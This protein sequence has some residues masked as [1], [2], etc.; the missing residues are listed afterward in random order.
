LLAVK[1]GSSVT[2]GFGTSLAGGVGTAA[3]TTA[4]TTAAGTATSAIVGQ[5]A[6]PIPLVGAAIGFIAG[7]VGPK[8]VG[9]V[10]DNA[11]KIAK[12][13]FAGV[14]AAAGLILGG[15]GST[16]AIGG[17]LIGTGLGY[18]VGS[19]LTGGI[20]AVQSSISSFA[21]GAGAAAGFV[22]TTFM[23]GVGTPI[24]VTLLAFPVVVALILFIINSGAYVVPP[25]SLFEKAGGA[26]PE[27]CLGDPPPKPDAGNVRF[28]ADNKYAYPVGI[29]PNP[30]YS[31]SPAGCYHWDGNK[32]AD[33]FNS[34]NPRSPLLAFEN[35]KIVNVKL[36]DKIGG[37]YVILQGA[38]SGRYY[39]YV[40][41]CHA[42]V[43]SGQTVKAGEVLGTMDETGSGRVEH[44]HFAINKSPLSDTF[45]G[46]DGNVCPYSDFE[47]KFSFGIC[48]PTSSCVNP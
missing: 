33:L 34:A 25:G 45:I 1:T 7:L 20:P 2:L 13:A 14:G 44:L 42:F 41:L 39:Y 8:V 16:G 47:E 9:W 5:V 10:K 3:E 19:L 37:K 27:D 6:I 38:T 12:F 29:F 28:S 21:S 22:W 35:G 17:G 18:G 30:P 23:A 36:N 46:G 26:T 43:A 31:G 32:S 11:S 40:H 15:A 4:I 24:L 48:S